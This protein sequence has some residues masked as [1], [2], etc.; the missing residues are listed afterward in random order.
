MV[1]TL[2][3]RISVTEQY[4]AHKSYKTVSEMFQAKF[5]GTDVPNKSTMSRIITKFHQHNTVCNLLHD[6]EKTALT[7]R[8]LATVSSELAPNDTLTSESLCQIIHEHHNE[9][10]SSGNV[11]RTT[12]ALRVYPY[13]VCV[14]HKL[15]PLDY[16]RCDV[17]S[18]VT[19]LHTNSPWHVEGSILF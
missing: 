15:L 9:G 2:Q 14:V 8:V 12:E 7:P 3:E 17:L 13:R 5:P 4:F 10:L 19:K 18:M 1:L 11:H 6:R 16:D